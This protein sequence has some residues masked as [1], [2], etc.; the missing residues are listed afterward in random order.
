MSIKRSVGYLQN[1]NNKVVRYL[2]INFRPRRVS[3]RGS[4]A[5]CNRQPNA[6]S[7]TGLRQPGGRWARTAGSSARDP[8]ETEKL[9]SRKTR[10]V[11]GATYTFFGGYIDIWEKEVALMLARACRACLTVNHR[12]FLLAGLRCNSARWFTHARHAR[13]STFVSLPTFFILVILKS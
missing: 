3:R 11:F 6:R 5:L 7:M 10:Y 2:N 13:A 1:V 9:L 12:Y 8:A 4:C